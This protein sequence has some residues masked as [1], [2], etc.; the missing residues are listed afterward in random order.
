MSEELSGTRRH[1]VSFTDGEWAL[2]VRAASLQG[3][4]PFSWLRQASVR[5]A[6]ANLAKAGRHSAPLTRRS[7]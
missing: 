6:E 1:T 4:D 7:V 5:A 2:I 3:K